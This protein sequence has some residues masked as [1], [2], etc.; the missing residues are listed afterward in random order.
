MEQICFARYYCLKFNNA[1]CSNL[2]SYSTLQ[3]IINKQ[4]KKI[5]KNLSSYSFR[6]MNWLRFRAGCPAHYL[7]WFHCLWISCFR[8]V[9]CQLIGWYSDKVTI[10]DWTGLRTEQMGVSDTCCGLWLVGG[11]WAWGGGEWVN[12]IE[13][14]SPPNV[15]LLSIFSFL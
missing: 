11:E 15:L 7:G 9:N 5:G 10:K 1:L 4:Q 12:K 6:F 3:P 14:Y 2:Y 8:R 13:H